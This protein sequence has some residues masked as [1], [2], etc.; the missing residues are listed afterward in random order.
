MLACERCTSLPLQACL[1]YPDLDCSQELSLRRQELED[2][3]QARLQAVQ[4]R[5]QQLEAEVNV[6][7]LQLEVGFSQDG[8][9]GPKLGLA[10]T[11]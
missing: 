2:S 1:G 4:R 9:R 8:G 11:S 10:Y 7:K 6:R 5:E 3:Y